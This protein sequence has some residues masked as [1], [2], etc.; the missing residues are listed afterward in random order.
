MKKY[1]YI[2]LVALL[3]FGCIPE[4]DPKL[5]TSTRFE[6]TVY[7]TEQCH[8]AM[9]YSNSEPKCNQNKCSVGPALRTNGLFSDVILSESWP[10]KCQ[11]SIAPIVHTISNQEGACSDDV[12]L[13]FWDQNQIDLFKEMDKSQ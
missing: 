6:I 5:D 13:C 11:Y 4:R 12:S 10:E 2:S 8:G 9:F 7:G 3:L 1:I